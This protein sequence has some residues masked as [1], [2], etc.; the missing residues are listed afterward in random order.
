MKRN[1]IF[2][3]VA[4][5][6]MVSAGWAQGPVTTYDCSSITD[7]PTIE[8]QARVALYDSTNGV[9]WTNNAGWLTGNKPCDWSGV[10]CDTGHVRSLWLV[11]N[12]L[13]GSISPDLG[14]LANLQ[15]LN[16][17]VNQLSGNIPESLGT[18]V[19]LKGVHLQN[20]QLSGPLPQ[21]MINLQQLDFFLFDR[22]RLCMPNDSAFANWY[23]GILT[24]VTDAKTCRGSQNH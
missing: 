4:F 23:A 9:S 24:R 14:N 12:N 3:S 10:A 20:N 15:E 7:I 19:K 6:L 1:G 2:I 22:A 8:C 13:S 5:A 21:S 17:A 11:D 16:L 18:L